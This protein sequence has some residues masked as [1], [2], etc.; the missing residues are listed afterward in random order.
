MI[1]WRAWRLRPEA[2]P[3]LAPVGTLYGALTGHAEPW[4]DGRHRARC[5]PPIERGWDRRPH[6]APGDRCECGIRGDLD[7]A[8][9][10]AYGS[11]PRATGHHGWKDWREVI[12][13]VELLGRR[14]PARLDDTPTTLRA[15]RARVGGRVFFARPLWDVADAFEALH[16]WSTAVRI[17]TLHKTAPCAASVAA[18]LQA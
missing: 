4:I 16:P 14:R 12:G 10:I 17:E 7:L 13:E 5:I 9:L 1:A 2:G 3:L 15:E 18:T 11:P 6:K 8:A